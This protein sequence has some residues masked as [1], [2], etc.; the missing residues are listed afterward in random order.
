MFKT[1]QRTEGGLAAVR[2]GAVAGAVSVLVFTIVH[3]LLISDIWFSL[4]MMMVAGVLC[5]LCVGW[6]YTVVETKPSL[7]GWLRYNLLYVATLAL[8]GAASVVAFEPETTMAALIAAN[9]PPEALIGQAMPLT[10]AFTLAAAL[11][12]TALYGPSRARF[13]AVLPTCIL[14]VLL[15]GLNVSAIGLVSIPRGSLYLV[16]EMFGLILTINLVYAGTFVALERAYLLRGT[17]LPPVQPEAG[18]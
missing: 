18:K 17:N 4:G 5:G 15:L 1:G 12:I 10:A 6:S 16:G 14:I 13:G 9:G 7:G 3:D 8:L 2:S 11:L